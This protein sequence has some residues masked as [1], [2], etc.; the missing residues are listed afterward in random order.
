MIRSIL[1]PTGF[2]ANS[3]K[4]AAYAAAIAR[5]TGAAVDLLHVIDFCLS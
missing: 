3:I 2:P 5:R 4:A 1:V